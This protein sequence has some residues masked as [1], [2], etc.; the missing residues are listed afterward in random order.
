MRDILYR[1]KGEDVYG[2]PSNKWLKGSIIEKVGYKPTYK[3]IWHGCIDWD[4]EDYI[5]EDTICQY[6]GITDNNRTKIFEGDFVKDEH[7]NIWRIFW[8]D[9]RYRFACTTT[10]SP[11]YL[12]GD[13]FG[14]DLLAKY[15][16]KEVVG[17]IF[18]NPEL[19][20]E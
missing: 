4:N 5:I 20:E 18:D 13:I 1:A 10:R 9:K 7:G 2:K 16:K 11:N 12:D 14:L 19:L 8:D 17:N 3:I 15:K 6:T